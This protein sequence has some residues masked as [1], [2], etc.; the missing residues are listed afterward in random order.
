MQGE[1]LDREV[2]LNGARLRLIE[3]RGETGPLLELLQYTSP[4]P[5]TGASEARPC[6]VGAHHIALAV[7]DIHKAHREL[8]EAGVKFTYAPQEVDAGY[9]QG[10]WTAYCFDPDGLIV[11]LWQT[12]EPSPAT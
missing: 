5:D 7:R 1:M 10:H 6:D 2:G 12:A 8:S 3:L 4:T 9:F 11:E